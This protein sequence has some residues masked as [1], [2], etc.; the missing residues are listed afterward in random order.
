MFSAT[1]DCKTEVILCRSKFLWLKKK[2]RKHAS[3]D[4]YCQLIYSRNNH[5]A[6][7]V[8]HQKSIVMNYWNF[9]NWPNFETWWLCLIEFPAL[10][11]LSDSQKV[12]SNSPQEAASSK[13]MSWGGWLK[14]WGIPTALMYNTFFRSFKTMLLIE[15]S[16]FTV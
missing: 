14:F 8:I 12:L 2:K 4:H 7:N 9:K 1:I 11:I 5:Y 6:H 13:E 3:C 10:W 15:V 16:L